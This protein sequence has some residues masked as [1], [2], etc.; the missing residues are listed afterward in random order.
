MY[1]ILVIAP[2]EG[3]GG[4]F[5]QAASRYPQLHLDLYTAPLEEA[6]SLVQE[7]D[8]RRYDAVVSRGRTVELLRGVLSK[9]I[10]DVNFSA[11]DIL[12]SLRLA[13]Y[14]SQKQMAMISFFELQDNAKKLCELLEYEK[15]VHFPP[16]A[17][18][19]TEMKE[20]VEQLY[21]KGIRLFIGDGPSMHMAKELGAETV[22]I[23][24]G[25]ESVENALLEVFSVCKSL[26]EIREQHQLFFQMVENT[27]IPFLVFDEAG[28]II[29]QNTAFA[30]SKKQLQDLVTANLQ[31][32]LR[33]KE[34]QFFI[35]QGEIAC[36]IHSFS[37][38]VGVHS[39]YVCRIQPVLPRMQKSAVC[40][41]WLSMQ[42]VLDD[43]ELI[44]HSTTLCGIKQRLNTPPYE[45]IPILLYGR[46]NGALLEMA[47]AIY[48]ASRWREQPLIIVDCMLMHEKT[49]QQLFGD[50]FSPLTEVGYTIFF[51]RIEA[52]PLLLQKKL[53]AAIEDTALS[54][55]HRVMAS[56]CG[57]MQESLRNGT[58]W[59][60]LYHL[61]ASSP[62]GV[63]ALRE[64]EDEIAPLA[65]AYLE[66]LNRSMPIQVAGFES[67]ALQCLRQYDWPGDLVQLR[68]VIRE[69][70]LVTEGELIKEETV[71]RILQEG[72]SESQA[73]PSF[74]FN[75]NRTLDEI[76]QEIIRMVLEEENMNRSKTAK[77]LGISRSTLWKK[78]NET[79]M[80]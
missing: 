68:Q 74:P 65:G 36:R 21:D 26:Q 17:A 35:N 67:G 11:F 24:S 71:Q 42:Q 34:K 38:Q 79:A 16:C 44:S 9:P 66:Q 20:Q 22:L 14:S 29:Y 12:R 57:N 32:I 31:R 70:A 77:R 6:V 4:L 58:F 52:L 47:K 23:T 56:F 48:S 43:A 73:K 78:L 1:H 62:V 30:K 50:E 13:N 60:R 76:D 25:T 27:D 75:L 15:E 18:D 8:M 33:Q 46:E 40:Y 41:E 80:P 64:I 63:P 7:L 53:C 72:R 28:S 45:K 59:G 37:M 19:M 69:C 3:F 5:Q 2:Y 61:M 54:L 49:L 51:H 10:I 55:R 39:Y